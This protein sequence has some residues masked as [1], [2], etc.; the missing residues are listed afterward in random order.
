MKA[1]GAENEGEYVI[2][3]IVTKIKYHLCLL[4]RAA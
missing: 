2:V 3:F 4:A 1:L